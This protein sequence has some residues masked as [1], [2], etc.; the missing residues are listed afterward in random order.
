M[1]RIG[2]LSKCVPSPEA[3][4]ISQ[5]ARAT[6][7][8]A[9]FGRRTDKK[10]HAVFTRSAADRETK[11]AP[12]NEHFVKMLAACGYADPQSTA[13]APVAYLKSSLSSYFEVYLM[14]TLFDAV[15]KMF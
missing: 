12:K 5:R 8:L 14:G 9:N 1:R 7:A 3:P 11:V 6:F 4:L 2:A 10:K 13:A 15:G